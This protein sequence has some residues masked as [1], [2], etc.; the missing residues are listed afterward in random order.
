MSF[1][2]LRLELTEEQCA[3]LAPL[4]AVARSPIQPHSLFAE[5]RR[6]TWPDDPKRLS[7]HVVAIPHDVAA[8]VRRAA[9]NV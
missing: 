1:P 2:T 4:V 9:S 7:L 3:Q 5:V 6:P 8:N